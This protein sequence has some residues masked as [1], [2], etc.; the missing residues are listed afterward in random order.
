MMR[1]RA[2][3]SVD[4]LDARFKPRARPLASPLVRRFFGSFSFW[5][6]VLPLTGACQIDQLAPP[7]TTT[8]L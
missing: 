6:C 4:A 8:E 5:L 2:F 3:S 7:G 1:R